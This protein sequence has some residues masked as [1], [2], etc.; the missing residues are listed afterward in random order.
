MSPIFAQIFFTNVC[1]TKYH[2]DDTPIKSFD[3]TPKKSH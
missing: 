2:V 3:D 1:K